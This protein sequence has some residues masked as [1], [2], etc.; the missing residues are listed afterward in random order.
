MG[1]ITSSN[2]KIYL[3]VTGVFT[4]PQPLQGFS[5]DDIFDLGNT[6]PV[7]AV[8]GVDGKLSGGR[9]NVAVPQTI[10]LQADSISNDVF[11]A[12]KQAQDKSGDVFFAQATVLLTSIGKEF[13]CVN[14]LLTDYKAAPDARRTLQPR[15]YQITWES[16]QVGNV[17]F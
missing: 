17:Q 11:D 1:S 16:W 15:H 9:I 4:T 14:G 2:A 3:A 10:V 5:A 13:T 6:P 8:M 7:E 12:W